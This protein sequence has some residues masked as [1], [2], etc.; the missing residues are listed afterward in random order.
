MTCRTPSARR[1]T[2]KISAWATCNGIFRSA[3]RL[4]RG[5]CSARC[6]ARGRVLPM[7]DPRRAPL[8]LIAQQD[9][10]A[11]GPTAV[12]G[13]TGLRRS[14]GYIDEEFLSRLRGINGVRFY[15][16]MMDNSSIVGSIMFVVKSLVRQVPW[17]I[18][19][20]PQAKNKDA[21]PRA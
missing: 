9:A 7:A 3:R 18:R 11:R 15:R 17:R 1:S 5:A 2:R 6:L 4:R 21:A 19:G 12:I 13:T 14:G 10:R 8:Q 20:P 16:Q